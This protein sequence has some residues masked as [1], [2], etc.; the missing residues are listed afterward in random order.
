MCL[1]S[2][3]IARQYRSAWQRPVRFAVGL[4]RDF[5]PR[6]FISVV[7]CLKRRSAGGRHFRVARIF[8]QPQRPASAAAGVKEVTMMV[9]TQLWNLFFVCFRALLEARPHHNAGR[10][11][12]GAV[13]GRWLASLNPLLAS[14]TILWIYV[15]FP[16]HFQMTHYLWP[17]EESDRAT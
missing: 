16:I 17:K 13:E 9:S 11:K 5:I 1:L 15:D 12:M 2:C 6:G 8:T 14:C 10:D 4:S 7:S 3:R